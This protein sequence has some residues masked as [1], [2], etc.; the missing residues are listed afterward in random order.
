MAPRFASWVFLAGLAGIVNH[1]LADEDL[2]KRGE[3]LVYAGGCIACH[4]DEENQGTP[5]A[6]GRA[7]V[8]PFGTFY[9]PNVTPDRETGIG[10]WSDTDFIRAFREGISPNGEHYYPAFPYTAYTGILREDLLTIKAYLFS[11]EPVQQPNRLHQLPWY[12]SWRASLTGWK[13]LN[14]ESGEFRPDP[15]RSEEWNR[16][17]YLVRHLGHCAEC[18]TPRDLT[19]GLKRQRELAGNPQGPEEEVVPNITPDDAT[20]IGRWSVSDITYFLESGMLPDG[21]FA[22]GAMGAV[23][24]DNTRHLSDEDRKAIAVYLKSLPPLPTAAE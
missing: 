2:V 12:A 11:L 8:T 17:A 9:T 13:W 7:L 3:Y 10:A 18:H 6:G 22:G 20:G 16:G 15:S 1:V 5:L 4:T 24:D 19:G 14:F 23:I 21:D